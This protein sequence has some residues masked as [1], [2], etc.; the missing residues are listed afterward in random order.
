MWILIIILALLV[1]VLAIVAL[2]WKIG[3]HAI[4]YFCVKNYREPTEEEIAECTRIAIGKM[5]GS[6][7]TRL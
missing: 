4:T 1:I 3:T 7:E 6:K 5:F 2:K